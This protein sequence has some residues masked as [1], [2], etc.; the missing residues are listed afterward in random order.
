M[1]IR[2]QSGE[3]WEQFAARKHAAIF[4]DPTLP[5]GRRTRTG[6]WHLYIGRR[7]KDPNVGSWQSACMV[8]HAAVGDE[9]IW[10]NLPDTDHQ[11]VCRRCLASW[12]LRRRCS[13][14]G[15]RIVVS[16][17][18]QPNK[19]ERLA[20]LIFKEAMSAGAAVPPDEIW[21]RFVA[22]LAEVGLRIVLVDEDGQ[23]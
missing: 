7:K 2:R 5:W 3:T 22:T 12:T 1:A 21:E 19:Q 8:G 10:A 9:I 20:R 16:K 11:R 15:E 17:I 18:K 13:I 23:P 14:E 6:T 4:D